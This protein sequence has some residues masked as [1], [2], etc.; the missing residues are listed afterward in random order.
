M[1]RKI[2][3][4]F[5]DGRGVPEAAWVSLMLR[6]PTVFE[7]VYAHYLPYSVMCGQWFTHSRATRARALKRFIH[8]PESA[9][10]NAVIQLEFHYS[11]NTIKNGDAINRAMR[12]YRKHRDK[13]LKLKCG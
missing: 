10:L 3:P 6:M 9:A 8:G 11:E 1:G 5:D 12:H 4:P 13:I 2:Y 7:A